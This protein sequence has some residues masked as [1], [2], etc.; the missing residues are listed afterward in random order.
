MLLPLLWAALWGGSQAQ[1]P[2]YRL[3]V[4]EVVRVPEGLCVLVPCRLRYPKDSWTE[5]TPAY[6]SWYKD[7]WTRQ[8]PY[9]GDPV[10]TNYPNRQVLPST[11]DR[12]Q[13]VVEPQDFSCSLRIREAQVGDSAQYFFRLERGPRVRYSFLESTLTL[14][15]IAQ[16]PEPVLYMPETL[17]PGRQVTIVC[18]F[19]WTF[20][21]CPVPAFSWRGA[22]LSAPGVARSHTHFSVV[23]LTPRVQD[24]DTALTCQ[25]DFSRASTERTVQLR[26]AHAP[27]ELRISTSQAD[28][29]APEP[30]SSGSQ[31]SRLDVREGQSLQLL[32]TADGWPPATLS[33]ALGNRVLAWSPSLGSRTLAL[34]LP[35]VKAGDAGRYTCRAENR[36]GA[37]SCWLDLAVQSAPDDLRVTASPANRTVLGSLGNGT[38][39]PVLEGQSLRLL[40]VTDSN[41]PA[42]LSWALGGRTLSPSQSTDP[43]VL[44]L[45]QIR[46]EQQGELTCLAQH[47]LGSQRVSLHLLVQYPPRL[48][49]PSCSL[50]EGGLLCSCSA[51]AQPAPAL[52][53]RLGEQLLEGSS[54]NSSVEVTFSHSGLWAN[55]SVRLG[56]LS[57]DLTLSCEAQ[58]PHGTRSTALLLQPGEKGL[59]SKTFSHGIL[60][61]TGATT[62][63]FCLTLILMKTLRRKGPRAERVTRRSTIL[64]YINVVPRAGPL[65]QNRKPKPSRPSQPPPP[66][67]VSPDSKGNQELHFIS[68]SRPGPKPPTQAP[69]AE[70]TQEDTHYAMLNFQ[71]LRPREAQ[72]PRASYSEY[73]EVK[74]Y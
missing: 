73:A 33:W 11:S 20:E 26:V 58:N 39:L 51:G 41:P 38:T 53:W 28:V 62:L 65:A 46:R 50:V 69:E 66:R 68:H 30:P 45:V 19:N 47:P 8:W 6:G 1:N 21:G 15:V 59:V 12:F 37:Q 43:G 55:S 13:L 29:P 18:V 23:T 44:E 48:L 2:L 56:A 61:G 34:T 60:L 31:A 40:C 52:R 10:A 14:E 35:Q 42:R 9:Y 72:A 64:D 16:T 25:V 17:E 54:S 36:L 63:L 71:A 74:F 67:A 32:C 7:P 57:P 27:R 5:S 3:E 24:H 49:G 4:Q 22:A 70:P